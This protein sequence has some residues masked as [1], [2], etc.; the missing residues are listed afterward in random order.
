MTAYALSVWGAYLALVL[1]AFWRSRVF[2][3]F[4]IVILLFPAG[5]GMALREHLGPLAPLVPYFQGAAAVQIAM[6]MGRPRM[7]PLPVRLL[8]TWPAQWFIAATFLAFPWGIA[9]ALG[10]TPHGAW[11]PFALTLGG[12]LQSLWTRE[13]T[14][15]LRLLPTRDAGELRRF[16]EGL[17]APAD[18]DAE[19][20]AGRPL[21]IVQITD[22]HLGPFMSVKRLARICQRAVE[23]KP[24]L[25]LLTGDLM[26]M[27]SHDLE[28]VSRALEPLRAYEGRVFACHGNHDHEAREVVRRAFARNGV[29]LLVDE[30][31]VVETEAGP[32]QIVGLDFVWR[33]RDTHVRMVCEDHPRK[34]GAL[35]V[36]LL[37][38]P[39]AFRHI[40]DGEGDL[41]LSGHTHGGQLGLLS[42]G[43]KHTFVSLFTKIPDHGP[44]ARG[45]NRLYVHRAQGHY[46]FPLR[47]GVPAEQSL[48]RVWREASLG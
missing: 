45:R 16:S 18:A 47:L 38:D 28:T 17:G 44:W 19:S 37:H 32:V 36:L 31:E 26:T 27:E 9:A 13:E 34:P 41:V 4:A 40:P 11:I 20:K 24:D 22:P 21:T 39:G 14:V 12:L 10:L 7:K 15:D 2:G 1:G 8:V 30:A 23:R 42:L 6:L 5:V 46:G 48:M 3:V 29:R 25:I 35:R 43:M 33:H